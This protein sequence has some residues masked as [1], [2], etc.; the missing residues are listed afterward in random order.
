MPCYVWLRWLTGCGAGPV[1]SGVRP[2]VPG[3]WRAPRCGIW[4]VLPP[5]RR[6]LAVTLLGAWAARVGTSRAVP[7]TGIRSRPWRVSENKI[8]AGHRDRLAVVYV[9][10]STRRQVVENT[11]STRLQYGL[12]ER[13]VALGWARSRVMVIDADLGVSASVPEARA[14]F[15]HRH[16]GDDGTCRDRGRDRDVAPGPVRTGLAPVAGAVLAVRDAAGRSG[17]G[18]RPHVLQRQVVAG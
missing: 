1:R 17:R 8:T 3:R 11:E 14:G 15:A 18:L 16:R 7:M 5:A 12:V 13:A 9:R 6:T 4:M 2:G 10:Q